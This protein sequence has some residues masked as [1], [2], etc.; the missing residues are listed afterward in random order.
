MRLSSTSPICK[1]LDAGLELHRGSNRFDRAGKLRQE[2]VAGVLHDGR[3]KRVLTDARLLMSV[4]GREPTNPQ[5]SFHV[6]CLG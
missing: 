5:T 1:F 6:R 4:I 2:P 3:A